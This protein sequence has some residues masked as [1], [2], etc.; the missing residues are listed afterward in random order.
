M[1]GISSNAANRLDNKFEYNGKE[2]QEKEFSD[3]SGLE[4]MDFGARMYD[5]QIG[6]WNHIDPLADQMRSWSPYN[7]AFN[8]PLRFIDPDGMAPGDFFDR[9]GQHLGTDGIDDGKVYVLNEHVVAKKGNTN[10]NWGGKLSEKHVENI[11]S[12]ST[13]IKMDSD[14]GHMIRTVYAESAGQSL[15]S[16]T[17]VAEVIRN[18]ATDQ[19]ENSSQNNWV[20]I[21]SNVDTYKDVVNQK[22]QFESVQADAP[23][24]VD[25]QSAIKD[26]KG[27]VIQAEKKSF[28]ESASASIKAHYRHTNTALGA[29]YF[30]S[31]YIKAPNWTK[32]AT[33]VNIPGVNANS[34]KFYKYGNQ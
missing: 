23:R 6:R 19:T 14:L 16:K 31:P 3:G 5:A 18:R 1:A 27:Q 9:D 33:E 11:K 30:Y 20:A 32:N 8:N 22:G 13:E 10:V 24:Y 28:L 25:P 12:M 2:K 15:E 34:F 17:A 21:F 26:K 7:F 29:T 4:W